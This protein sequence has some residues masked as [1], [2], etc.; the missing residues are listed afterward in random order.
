MG[1][2]RFQLDSLGHVARVEHDPA[3]SFVLA[4]IGHVRLEVPP[5]AR[6]VQHAQDDLA[7]AAAGRRGSHDRTV[8]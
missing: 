7:A 8:L 6:L 4:E 1:Q 3:D 5:F 2:L